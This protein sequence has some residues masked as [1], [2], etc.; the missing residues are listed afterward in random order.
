LV[1]ALLLSRLLSSAAHVKEVIIRSIH[2][3]LGAQ[4]AEYLV[5]IQKGTFESA[6]LVQKKTLVF[7]RARCGQEPF[8]SASLALAIAMSVQNLKAYFKARL[9]ICDTFG[10]AE[11]LEKYFSGLLGYC[12]DY[13]NPLQFDKKVMKI[14]MK[15][16]KKDIIVTELRVKTSFWKLVPWVICGA[17]STDPEVARGSTERLPNYLQRAPQLVFSRGSTSRAVIDMDKN[18]KQKTSGPKQNVEPIPLKHF[19]EDLPHKCELVVKPVPSTDHAL[20][21]LFEDEKVAMLAQEHMLQWMGHNSFVNLTNHPCAE[22]LTEEE[23][24][25]VMQA[26][27]A[28]AISGSGRGL[29]C[30]GFTEG[31]SNAAESLVSKG[32]LR[33]MN[34][35]DDGSPMVQLSTKMVSWTLTLQKPEKVFKIR[36]GVSFD[37]ANIIALGKGGRPTTFEVESKLL[38]CGWKFFNG[39]LKALC[40]STSELLFNMKRRFWYHV[41]LLNAKHIFEKGTKCIYHKQSESYYHALLHCPT[42]TTVDPNKAAAHYKELVGKGTLSTPRLAMLEFE[43][44]EDDEKTNGDDAAASG[45]GEGEEIENQDDNDAEPGGASPDQ[46]LEENDTDKDAKH[47]GGNQD[48]SQGILPSVAKYMS[49]RVNID[50]VAAEDRLKL[51]SIRSALL[52]IEEV[53]PAKVIWGETDMPYKSHYNAERAI[54]NLYWD[55]L[56]E[57]VNKRKEIDLA[58]APTSKSSKMVK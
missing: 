8:R 23:L 42:G 54:A 56:V 40:P 19:R 55:Q 52:K 44:D 39:R 22:Q 25:V 7:G 15:T 46:D 38:A 9:V 2:F 11:T 1:E 30:E 27:E 29:I 4:A 31:E 10:D 17:A 13:G 58:K 34:A 5:G 36:E 45:D 12:A 6:F 48:P 47:T 50:E 21:T 35:S 26:F 37:I 33:N 16:D 20:L 53:R 51:Q 49:R 32:M 43:Q 41:A 57:M 28:S 18:N 14:N 24:D 3:A